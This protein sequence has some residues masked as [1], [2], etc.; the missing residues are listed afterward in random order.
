MSILNY[1]EFIKI[2]NDQR[3]FILLPKDLKCYNIQY[4]DN[5]FTINNFNDTEYINVTTK[6]YILQWLK[7][8]VESYYFCEII[9]N[10]NAEFG[11]FGNKIKTNICDV[12]TFCKIQNII[13]YLHQEIGLTKEHFKLNDNF[14]CRWACK[15][16]YI[17]AIKYL[18]QE[19][20]LTKQ[21]FQSRNNLICIFACENNHVD[22]VKYLHQE[23]GLTKQ[24]FQSRNNYAYQKACEYGY[25]DV[26]K[27]LEQEI[28][29]DNY[30]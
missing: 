9:P 24:D 13:Q 6:Y 11:I 4:R 25:F 17:E 30:V 1:D 29:I 8:A 2:N 10:K 18:H 28:F 27:Y 3:L 23:I 15:N 16:G 22:V 26:V 21:D 20:G 7:D 19:I 5:I 14:V 12:V